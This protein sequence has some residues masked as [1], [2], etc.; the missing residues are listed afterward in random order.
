MTDLNDT[1]LHALDRRRS[2][3]GEHIEIAF[4]AA[5]EPALT[6]APQAEIEELLDILAADGA[7]AMPAGG[8]LHV[9]VSHTSV[10]D[11]FAAL[12]L[13]VPLGDYVVLSVTDSGDGAVSD[14]PLGTRLSGARVIAERHGGAISDHRSPGIGTV[15]RAFLPAV[16]PSSHAPAT[17]ET[18]PLGDETIL[19][20]EDEPAVRGYLSAILAEQGYNV[21]SA[22]GAREAELIAS[23]HEGPLDLLLTDMAVP[24]SSGFEIAARIG[25]LRPGITVL[26][27]SGHAGPAG[28]GADHILEKP[29]R[30]AVLLQ[31]IRTLL[32]CA[33]QR[34]AVAAPER[35]PPSPLS[36]ADP[37]AASPA[38][39]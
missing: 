37:E 23:R 28:A 20:V 12:C 35:T 22:A 3:L 8:T 15:V 10:R 9:G 1:A 7:G 36:A 29:F 16:G 39:E 13:S 4:S 30:P 17:E 31:R 21:L 5:P 33:P 34:R 25:A 6:L 18:A 32:D 38:T 14:T 24:G 2:A 27:M 11:S 19:L 26:R